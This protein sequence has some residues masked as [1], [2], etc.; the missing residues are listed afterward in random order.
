MGRK[1][2]KMSGLELFAIAI[3]AFV[4]YIAVTFVC[5]TL[6]STDYD[7]DF[8]GIVWL[9]GAAMFVTIIVMWAMGEPFPFRE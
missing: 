5:A 1:A 6:V 2:E 8:M 3:I 7:E 4:V 9:S